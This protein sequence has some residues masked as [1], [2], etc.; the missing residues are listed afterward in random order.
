[1]RLPHEHPRT[2]PELA[3]DAAPKS[4]EPRRLIPARS[5]SAG[6]GPWGTVWASG[7]FDVAA[8]RQPPPRTPAAHYQPGRGVPP[9]V[10]G[11][12]F[13]PS[14]CRKPAD[15]AGPRIGC[16]AARQRVRGAVPAGQGGRAAGAAAWLLHPEDRGHHRAAGCRMDSFRSSGQLVVADRG[17]RVPG[18]DLHPDRVP[19]PRRRA[20]A[21]FRHQAGQ[22]RR[23]RPARQP[24][25]R[26]ELRLV[27]RQAQPPP[28]P[29]QHRGR[30]SRHLRWRVCL[31]RRAGPRQPRPGPADV[32]LPGVPVLPAAAAGSGQPA[33]R[34]RP[35]R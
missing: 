12:I 30:R 2:A 24:R 14:I 29:P 7:A 8:A 5:P 18:G 25:H 6:P 23:R 20:P 21:D 16:A 4:P 3:P 31:H 17:C 1:M 32:P 28:R 13:R 34:E 19:G 10:P 26:A 33:C 9:G 22:L 11:A 27:D 15:A 35:G